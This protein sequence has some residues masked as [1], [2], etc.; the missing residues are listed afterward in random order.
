[1]NISI[2]PLVLPVAALVFLGTSIFSSAAD[3]APD[4]PS[5]WKLADSN[6][7]TWEVANNPADKAA[8][9]K[10]FNAQCASC[11][12]DTIEMSGLQISPIITYGTY[13]LKDRAGLVLKRTIVWPLL[14]KSNP[15]PGA[16][17]HDHWAETF[18]K[19]VSPRFVVDG[20]EIKDENVL[21]FR[22]TQ[23]TLVIESELGPKNEIAL[24]RTISPSVDAPTYI[25]EYAFKNRSDRPVRLA[26]TATPKT[27]TTDAKRGMFG[28]YGI[29][30]VFGDI[31]ETT[32]AP[33]DTVSSAL[34]ITGS[35]VSEVPTP[36]SPATPPASSESYLA[37][38]HAAVAN[39]QNKL[40]LETPDP[41]LNTA[42][43]FAKIRAAESIFKTAAGP[44]HSPGGNS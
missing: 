19:E 39:W 37:A 33:G 9:G 21:R 34:F 28:S 24:T 38:R 11:H 18:G 14:R 16:R 7:I 10:R 41:V 44:L 1:M 12:T 29:A 43:A 17:T 23:G 26:A 20:T 3:P 8:Q 40:R 6:S 31:K 25:E 27:F 5:R 2:R 35:K 42:F 4:I 30:A 22:H 15:R 32:L 36:T 13:G